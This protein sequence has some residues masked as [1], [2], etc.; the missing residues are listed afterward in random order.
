LFQMRK[1]GPYRRELP[2]KTLIDGIKGTEETNPIDSKEA[3]PEAPSPERA[4]HKLDQQVLNKK[5]KV[6]LSDM[7]ETIPR[8][9]YLWFSEAGDLS[10]P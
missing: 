7:V 1:K 2:K 8:V 5:K 9:K 10:R 4:N 3:E 6:T